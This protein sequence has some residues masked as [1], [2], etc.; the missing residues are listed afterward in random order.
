MSF[1]RITLNSELAHTWKSKHT[2]SDVTTIR[3]IYRWGA[4]WGILNLK[5]NEWTVE[6]REALVMQPYLLE[7]VQF[8]TIQAPP[9]TV[10]DIWEE[11]IQSQGKTVW[12][13]E[14]VTVCL[15][16]EELKKW[17]SQESLELPEGLEI[18]CNSVGQ[19]ESS[20]PKPKQPTPSSKYQNQNY[21]QNRNRY[22]NGNSKH[23][24]THQRPMGGKCF[25]ED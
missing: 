5:T 9:P 6:T 17:C 22:P 25:I 16:G 7:K 1:Y 21:N 24:F 4:F 20:F 10:D 23:S 18:D 3:R 11:E 15:S 8:H 2:L 12:N 19:I 14:L 13:G